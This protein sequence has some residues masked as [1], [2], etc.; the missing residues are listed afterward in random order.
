MTLLK[1]LVFAAF[2][3]L[4]LS[5]QA[6]D[7]P[8]KLDGCKIVSAT[9]AQALMGKGAKLFDTRVATEFA[10]EHIKDAISLPYGE[11]SKKEV[12]FDAL[13]NDPD[14]M[15]D[16][17]D[18]SK[19]PASNMIFQ[20]NGKDCWKS[21]KACKWAHKKS[22]KDLY[23]LRGGIPEWKAKGLPTEK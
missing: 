15:I 6:A 13:F 18:D 9:E 4:G 20:C 5:A 11:K 12:A 2:L 19:L 21:F 8:E 7:T 22:K 17:F 3:A 10:E 16:S 23:W 14:K 1:T